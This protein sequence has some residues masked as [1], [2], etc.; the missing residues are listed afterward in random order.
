[1]ADPIGSP[2]GITASFVAIF[3]LTT[4]VI[5]YINNFKDASQ[6]R[7]RLRDEISSAC[8]SLYMLK[9]RLDQTDRD[10][11]QLPSVQV[12]S[13]PN[14][15]MSQFK[16][17]LEQLTSKVDPQ[18]GKKN[19]IDHVT[20][21][22]MWP[23]KK[24]EVRALLSA[25]ERQKS[26]FHLALQ[27]D[28]M[29]LTQAIKETTSRLPALADNI[30]V[31]NEHVKY[32][33][34]NEKASE[35]RQ[36]VRWLSPLNF[37]PTQEDLFSR[38][39]EGTGEWFLKSAQF[40]DWLNSAGGTL[41]CP[42]IPG[43]GKT[44]LTSIAV[45]YIR[46]TH[47][48]R[49]D[50]RIGV[51]CIYCNYKEQHVQSPLNL[52]ASVWMQ[53]VQSKDIISD[54]VK[55]IYE[56]YFDKG[57]R[58]NLKKVLEILQEEV[59]KYERVFVLVDAL[60][61]CID[62]HSRE[63]LVEQLRTLRPK[64]NLMT[65]SRRLDNIA[66][67]FSGAPMLEINAQPTDICAYVNNRIARGSRLSRHV[68][69]DKNLA[70]E[71]RR[72]VVRTSENMFLLAQ[73][74]MDSLVSRTSRKSVRQALDKLPKD[75]DTTYEEAMLRIE[76]QNDDDKQLAWK[77]LSWI[78]FAARPLLL[79]ELRDAVAVEPEM[80]HLDKD[81][82]HDEELLT[83][84]CVGLV[85]VD[86]TSQIVRLC[87]YS[88][89][90]YLD[91][92]RTLR[93]PTAQ[94]NISKT[95]L[96]YLLFREFEHGP[97]VE[98]EALLRI[99]EYPL[100][101]Y[102]ATNW[103]KH[104]QG[105]PEQLLQEIVLKFLNSEKPLG[106]SV[107]CA[108]LTTSSYTKPQSYPRNVTGLHV[109]AQFGLKHLTEVLLSQGSNIAAR[110]S[111]GRNALTI[112]AS[113][114]H[115]AVVELLLDRGADITATDECEWTALHKAARGGHKAIVELLL[116][117][118]ADITA[119][120]I[121]GWTS[122]HVAARD[123]HEA[124]VKL[125]VDK[126][127]DIMAEA[128]FGWTV[129]HTAMTSGNKAV[130]FLLLEKGAS[131]SKGMNARTALHIAANFGYAKSAN[132]LLRGP[133]INSTPW[134]AAKWYQDMSV[135]L[136]DCGRTVEDHF[137]NLLTTPLYEAIKRG[138][139]AVAG[140]LLK[141]KASVQW[142]SDEGWTPLYE[143][144]RRSSRR[145]I[146]ILLER[147]ICPQAPKFATPKVIC[148]NGGSFYAIEQPRKEERNP[149]LTSYYYLMNSQ[150]TS[151]R[152]TLLGLPFAR[153]CRIDEFDTK[154]GQTALHK[155]AHRGDIDCVQWLLDHG[156]DPK[157]KNWHGQD[158]TQIALASSKEDVVALLSSYRFLPDSI[159]DYELF[160]ML[161]ICITVF[162]YL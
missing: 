118:G 129:L 52:I 4:T 56:G 107:Q 49:L 8:F 106:W 136:F 70:E 78:S 122:L 57:T 105:S 140:V 100:L 147:G 117:R 33:H 155:A 150:P 108:Y 113:N 90:E 32:L 111:D 145:I 89:E 10:I 104:L 68:E 15:P 134:K 25:M 158:A 34:T 87:H 85:I 73:L 45:E 93:F 132:S 148:N 161:Q 44:T 121:Y 30:E 159:D 54:K 74:H 39:I 154:N 138:H 40:E 35:K 29:S 146:E 115:A 18:N 53:L 20:R 130:V 116:I 5:N 58:P 157:I 66:R 1:M 11:S 13:E 21:N 80:H 144:V 71:I 60:D 141:L 28:V 83:S 81:D 160:K 6:E 27:N 127:A 69:S 120:E 42:G 23:F 151:V 95:C 38:S 79:D 131:I 62:D 47:K 76:H 22:L 109:S 48:D 72:N 91:R 82:R 46:E 65:M 17:Q 84:V 99:K 50:S 77:V 2:I 86:Q 162:R 96:T 128:K 143:A 97:V 64:I 67:I 7:L 16:Q 153:D 98:D 156:A 124:I 114:G 110:D 63:I 41:W 36:I 139:V 119:R 31:T 92:T 88:T 12:L 75:L 142:T 123:G 9:E 101:S 133:W 43:A 19:R 149:L 37:F 61:E 94:L 55:N 14:G 152:S 137:E 102:A 125:L 3:Q 26:L 51:A 59:Q 24:E 103:G 126:G 112:A 135:V